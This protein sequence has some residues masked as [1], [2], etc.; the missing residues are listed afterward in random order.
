MKFLSLAVVALFVAL[1]FVSPAN[2]QN[3]AFAP[4]ADA[5]ISFTGTGNNVV[6]V[7]LTG[8]SNPNY[9]VGGGIES[10]TKHL[11]LDI[12]GQFDSASFAGIEGVFKNTGGYT[13]TATGSAYYK[14]GGVLLVGGG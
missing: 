2:A 10:S 1:A 9:R 6:G 7:N 14:L 13:L 5:N 3:G 4:Y 12:N 8:V 11:L